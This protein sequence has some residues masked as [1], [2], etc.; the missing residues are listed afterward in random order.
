MEAAQLVVLCYEN[1]GGEHIPGVPGDAVYGVNLWK[2]M[3]KIQRCAHVDFTNQV[4]VEHTESLGSAGRRA[5]DPRQLQGILKKVLAQST[6]GIIDCPG[7][8]SENLKLTEQLG[9]LGCPI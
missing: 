2:P 3:L 6:V 4:F 1:E 9:K 5:T 7:D 8:C